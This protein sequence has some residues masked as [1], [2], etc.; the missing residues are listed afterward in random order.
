MAASSTASPVLPL[1]FWSP[2]RERLRAWTTGFRALGF[3]VFGSG[4]WGLGFGFRVWGV[5]SMVLGFG[6][7]V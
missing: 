4:L 6:L 2:A 1:E 7:R 3:R 5:G